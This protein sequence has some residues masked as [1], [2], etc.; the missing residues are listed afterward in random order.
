MCSIKANRDIGDQ[1]KRIRPVFS[2]TLQIIPY[3]HSLHT[4]HRM[5]YYHL[6]LSSKV[7]IAKCVK[8][9]FSD[10]RSYVMHKIR[11]SVKRRYDPVSVCTIESQLRSVGREISLKIVWLA[12]CS[13]CEPVG[14][15]T[16]GGLL[17]HS[18]MKTNSEKKLNCRNKELENPI[19]IFTYYIH[20]TLVKPT[21]VAYM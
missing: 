13:S 15:F 21:H 5:R 4:S 16:C 7:R 8:W 10:D 2:F 11:D 19:V 12:C 6:I 3:M 17:I 9:R 1:Y 18:G 20:L 14:G